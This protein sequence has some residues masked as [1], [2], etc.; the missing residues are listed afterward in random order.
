MRSSPASPTGSSFGLNMVHS[1]LDAQNISFPVKGSAALSPKEFPDLQRYAGQKVDTG[2]KAKA[3]ANGFIRRHLITAG[4]G[5]T[6]SQ[7]STASQADPTNAK[8]SAEVE[9]LPIDLRA[10]QP[11]AARNP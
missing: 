7:V 6:Y 11:V 10:G 2:D 9:T 8:L 1:Q 5:Q 4:G 3:Y